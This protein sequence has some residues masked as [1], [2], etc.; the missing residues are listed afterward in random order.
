[1][2]ELVEFYKAIKVSDSSVSF[3]QPPLTSFYAFAHS[4]TMPFLRED[5]KERI[6]HGPGLIP[7]VFTLK[8][9]KR[10]KYANIFRFVIDSRKKIRT[11]DLSNWKSHVGS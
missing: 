11:F 4:L 3:R 9:W 6:L 8:K 2:I 5:N 7:I 10:K 1:M